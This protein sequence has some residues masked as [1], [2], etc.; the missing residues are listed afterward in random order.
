MRDEWFAGGLP[1]WPLILGGGSA[2]STKEG[3]QSLLMIKFKPNLALCHLCGD[4]CGT[5]ICPACQQDLPRLGLCCPVC[6]LPSTCPDTPCGDC[7]GLDKPY[8]RSVCAF[9]YTHPMDLLIHQLKTGSVVANARCLVPMLV[10]KIR[11]AYSDQT[12]PD[13]IVPVPSHWRTRLKRGYNPAE[14]LAQ[15]LS[16]ELNIP[17]ARW[18][19]KQ[20]YSPA[21]KQLN[22]RER[23]ANLKGSFNCPQDLAQK[24]LS[25]A[26][27]DDVITTCA[28]VIRASQSLRAAGAHSIDVWALARTP[29]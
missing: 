18:L 12:F 17:T 1:Q 26:L 16:M 15:R 3:T 19:R 2:L 25:I 13:V 7:L 6:A 21:Q 9:I 22:R 14:H 11:G 29:K 20:H 8:R 23:L 5:Y 27:V 24:N 28:T 10:E 4:S